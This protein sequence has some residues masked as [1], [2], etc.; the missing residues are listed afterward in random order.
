MVSLGTTKEVMFR[1]SVWF[2]LI[3]SPQSSL[4]RQASKHSRRSDKYD[5]SST[6]GFARVVSF[7]N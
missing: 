5:V 3:S 4:N 6:L 2:C 1:V 7:S